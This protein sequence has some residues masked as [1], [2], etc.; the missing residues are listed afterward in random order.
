MGPCVRWDIRP[1]RISKLD[2]RENLFARNSLRNCQIVFTFCTDHGR[3]YVV[4]FAKFQNECTNGI[5]VMD[6]RCFTRVEFN[7]SPILLSLRGE[8]FYEVSHWSQNWLNC[9]QKRCHIHAERVIGLQNWLICQKKLTQ[10][11]F[12]ETLGSKLQTIR[13]SFIY[14]IS[15]WSFLRCSGLWCSIGLHFLLHAFWLQHTSK[16]IWPLADTKVTNWNYTLNWCFPWDQWRRPRRYFQ[17]RFVKETDTS[18]NIVIDKSAWIY[19]IAWHC[20]F[21]N[22]NLWLRLLTQKCV[23][24]NQDYTHGVSY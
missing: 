15:P 18:Q 6:E 19:M 2:F 8:K 9:H 10:N 5:D 12:W 3:D 21:V 22:H 13:L 16:D 20:N 23:I 24:S 7:V 4:L 1:K 11:K 14:N 17:G